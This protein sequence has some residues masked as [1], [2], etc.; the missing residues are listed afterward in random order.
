MKLL[1]QFRDSAT[2][3]RQSEKEELEEEEQEEE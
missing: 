3:S 2:D 1:G